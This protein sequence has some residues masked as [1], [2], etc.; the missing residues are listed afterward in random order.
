MLTRDGACAL[1]RGSS[2]H[3]VSQPPQNPRS[4]IA[5]RLIVLSQEYRFR[6]RQLFGRDGKFPRV[7]WGLDAWQID[8]EG[9]PLPHLAVDPHV[10]A[11]LLDDAVHRGESETRPLADLLG[12]EE[13]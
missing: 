5:E 6:S 1:R 7:G 4:Q 11:R 12:G 9:G 2:Q 13:G 3:R 8:L 10:P